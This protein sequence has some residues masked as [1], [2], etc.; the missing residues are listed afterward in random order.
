M[1][2]VVV[3]AN[4]SEL[5]GFVRSTSFGHPT[6]LTNVIGLNLKRLKPV[7]PSSPSRYRSTWKAGLSPR[8]LQPSIPSP[9][10]LH[11]STTHRM[12]QSLLFERR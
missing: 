1:S 9:L 3:K 6:P 8:S 12:R 4:E 7:S 11:Y 2:A 5:E 10:R